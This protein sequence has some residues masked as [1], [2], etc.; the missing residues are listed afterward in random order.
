MDSLL[1]IEELYVS[2]NI[3]MGHLRYGYRKIWALR[4]INLDVPQGIAIGI[5]GGSGSGKSTILRAILGFVKPEKGRIIFKG[6]DLLRAGRSIRKEISRDIGYVPQEPSQSINPKMRVLEVLSEPLRPLRLPKD[7]VEK[8]VDIVLE[9]LDLSSPIKNMYVKEVSG[10]MLQRIAIA[11]AL[12]TKPKLMLLDEPTSNLD[13]SMQAQILNILKDLKEQLG[14]TYLLVS[15]DIDVV[16]YIAERI[17]IIISGRI[18]EE[19]DTNTILTE[20]LHPYTEIL[21]NPEKTAENIVFVDGNLCPI[22][23]WCPYR[24]PICLV[25][26]PPRVYL[27]NRYV[28][29]WRYSNNIH[30]RHND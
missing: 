22:A 8:R 9:M 15:H 28:V 5:V 20:P 1:R 21:L 12:I 24:L 11:R 14:L 4:G 18:V 30:S 19:G 16:G 6:I 13:I 3:P 27:S 17:A 23:N 7:D 25:K 26:H 29:C 2:Y 10:G